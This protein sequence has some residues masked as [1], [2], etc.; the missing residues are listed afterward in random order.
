L[1]VEKKV[2]EALAVYRQA[3]ELAPEI[4]EFQFWY[5]ATLVVVDKETEAAGLFKDLFAKEPFW[6]D[7][8]RRLPAAGLFPSDPV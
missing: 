2:E 8:L 4:L 3:M 7:V 6:V 5:A 1:I